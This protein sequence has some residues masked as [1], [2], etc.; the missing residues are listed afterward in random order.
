MKK[1]LFTLCCSII[2]ITAFTQT[3]DDV[4]NM[5][6]PQLQGDARYLATGG[7]FGAL[8]GNIY[9]IGTNPAGAGVFINN[10]FS[11]SLGFPLAISNSIGG[12]NG[13]SSTAQL[14]IPNIGVVGN[15]NIPKSQLKAF[16]ISITNNRVQDYY[17]SNS[18]NAISNHSLADFFTEQANGFYASEFS[19]DANEA[20]L[21]FTSYL[22]YQAYL[23]NP[24]SD[25]QD[26]NQ[27]YSAF[28]NEV[29]RQTITYKQRGAMSETNIT[30]GLNFMDKYCT[31]T[32]L[33]Q[34]NPFRNI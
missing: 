17:K 12:L 25:T 18:V 26:T 14:T 20:P 31:F 3:V 24:V 19:A 9:A 21:P 5:S 1:V 7:A 33:F 29:S 13:N 8:G 30:G 10:E 32:L 11:V 34:S 15:V 28:E 2:G 27:Y 23:I 16:N 4:Y 22:A 6:N